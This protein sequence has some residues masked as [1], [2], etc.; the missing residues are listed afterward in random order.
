[1]DARAL[2]YGTKD[3]VA[4]T[5]D[6]KFAGRHL[7][8]NKTGPELGYQPAEGRIGYPSHRRQHDAISHCNV[9]DAERGCFRSVVFFGDCSVHIL[10]IL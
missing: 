4:I 2:S 1:M 5:L 6:Q 10:P 9:A 8:H 3:G 7:G